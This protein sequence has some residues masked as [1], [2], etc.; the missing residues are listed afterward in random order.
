MYIKPRWYIAYFGPAN[1]QIVV[2]AEGD[3]TVEGGGAFLSGAAKQ[4]ASPV[5]L[6]A[7][8]GAYSQFD[9]WEY[10]YTRRHTY[11]YDASASGVGHTRDYPTISRLK[12]DEDT[13]GQTS[14]ITLDPSTILD[15]VVEIKA[16]FVLVNPGKLLYGAQGTLLYADSDGSLLCVG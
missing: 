15:G 12:V 5:T 14:A 16:V 4:G 8:P 11:H 7:T 9:H 2:S 3:G 1:L 13:A 6:T 10:Q